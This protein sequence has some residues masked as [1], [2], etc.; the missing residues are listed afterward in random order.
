[1]KENEQSDFWGQLQPTLHSSV[2]FTLHRTECENNEEEMDVDCEALA[3][4][5]QC[6]TRPKFMYSYCRKEC[7]KCDAETS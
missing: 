1:M 3:A 4:D 5:N 2:L 6:V 7:L